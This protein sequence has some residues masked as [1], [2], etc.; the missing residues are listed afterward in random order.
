[1][2]INITVVG[3]MNKLCVAVTSCPT[4]QPGIAE[5]GDMIKSNFRKLRDAAA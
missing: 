4:Q 1:M 3:Y 5:F 2:G